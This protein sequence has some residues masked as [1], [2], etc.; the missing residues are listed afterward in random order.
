MQDAFVRLAQAR[1]A[2]A[3][4]KPQAYL[5][6]IVG[7]LLR[8]RAK[9]G[10]HRIVVFDDFLCA[11]L[12]PAA[13]PEQE[14]NLEVSDLR[15]SYA[16]ALAELT[17]RTR[18]VFLLH[19]VEELRYRDIADRLGITVPTVE[20]HMARALVHLDKALIQ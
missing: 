8:D 13:S 15:R 2:A 6:R 18:E 1:P 9:R 3:L 10:R 5:Q 14:W 20:Y 4:R 12:E 19:R 11:A 7:N 16:A 17:P